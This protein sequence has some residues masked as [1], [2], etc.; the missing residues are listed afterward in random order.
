M[1]DPSPGTIL[2]GVG[3]FVNRL[4]RELT[5]L[6]LPEIVSNL[7]DL[8]SPRTQAATQDIRHQ[9]PFSR[10]PPA[11]LSTLKPIMLTLHCLFPNDLL[12]ALDILDRGLVQRLVREDNLDTM[13]SVSNYA[14][15]VTTEG[16]GAWQGTE[17]ASDLD[18]PNQDVYLVTSASAARDSAAS[19]TTTTTHGQEK[20]YEVRLR[21]WNC[22]CPT[23]TLSAFRDF[24]L[25][26]DPAAERPSCDEMLHGQDLIYPFGGTLNCATDRMSPPICKH[27]LACLLF[28]RCPRVVKAK[29]DGIRMVSLEELA[30]WC[31]GWG[32]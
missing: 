25:R 19:S 31:A 32:G 2:P 22:T 18:Q 26:A 29:G 8:E 28:A 21:A 14:Q 24:P 27:L 30:G 7:G 12:P 3:N 15:N 9:N 5:E 20:G 4:L 10:L 6:K 17:L 16:Q 23:F 13:S 1:D 11:E